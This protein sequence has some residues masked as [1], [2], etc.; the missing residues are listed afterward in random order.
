MPATRKIFRFGIPVIVPEFQM[1]ATR[2]NMTKVL[3]MRRLGGE[4]VGRK[5]AILTSNISL[6]QTVTNIAATPSREN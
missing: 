4:I 5:V 1:P 2:K 6:N 3:L